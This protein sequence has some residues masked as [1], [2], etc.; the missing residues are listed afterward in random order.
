MAY[1]LANTRA[2]SGAFFFAMDAQKMTLNYFHL[3][4]MGDGWDGGGEQSLNSHSSISE[5][6]QCIEVLKISQNSW[7]ESCV[8]VYTTARWEKQTTF[9][10]GTYEKES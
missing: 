10:S 3:W 9:P 6:H 1:S 4:V 5:I 2:S 8:C 7:L